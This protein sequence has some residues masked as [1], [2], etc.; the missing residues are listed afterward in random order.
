MNPMTQY[1][2]G[3]TDPAV[4]SNPLAGLALASAV[5][6]PLLLVSRI[7]LPLLP[8]ALLTAF[9]LGIVARV[10]AGKDGPGR[11]LAT[12]AVVISAVPIALF[13]VL[14]VGLFVVFG[15]GGFR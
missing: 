11:G 14:V 3:P 9:V 4:R 2:G 13:S 5:A 12:T 6:A 1:P 15:L 7:G 8:V 10:R